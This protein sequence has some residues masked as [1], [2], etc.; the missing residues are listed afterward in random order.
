MS[1]DDNRGIVGEH[2]GLAAIVNAC[3]EIDRHTLTPSL[4]WMTP[5]REPAGVCKFQSLDSTGIL[6]QCNKYAKEKL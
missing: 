2:Y 3:L 4:C 1:H 5:N 6:Y